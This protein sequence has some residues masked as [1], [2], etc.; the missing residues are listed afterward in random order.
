[1]LPTCLVT[2]KLDEQMISDELDVLRHE[3]AVHANHAHRQRIGQKL[4]L[5]LNCIADDFMNALL[6]RFLHQVPAK[7][8]VLLVLSRNARGTHLYMRQAKSVCIPSSREMSSLENVRPGMRPRFFS[9]KIAANEPEKK[10]PSTAANA[11][12]RSPECSGGNSKT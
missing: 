6:R 3:R 1:M 9:Q 5:N 11:I 2:I 10:M 12:T 8:V 7:V 4:L